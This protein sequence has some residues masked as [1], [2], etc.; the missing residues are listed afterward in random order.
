MITSRKI[1]EISIFLLYSNDAQL[2]MGWDAKR[3]ITLSSTYSCVKN[4]RKGNMEK[5]P[6]L[7]WQGGTPQVRLPFKM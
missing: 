7:N 1:N 6:N 4:K 3:I 2:E 5:D